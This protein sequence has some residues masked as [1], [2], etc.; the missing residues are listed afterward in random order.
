LIIETLERALAELLEAGRVAT[1]KKWLELAAVAA[2]HHSGL[3]LAE[4]EVALRD[5]DP[6][7]AQVLGERS[8]FLSRGGDAAAR[9]H[10]VAARAAH[11]RDD[12]EGVTRNVK[13]AE[14][15]ATTMATKANALWIH[16]S[17]ALERGDE[18]VS[19]ILDRLRA[20]PD[21]SAEFA[22]RLRNAEG[23]MLFEAHADVRAS[24]RAY[25]L[26][27]ALLPHV[28]DPFSRTALLNQRAYVLT[29]LGSY[30]D[31][32]RV[33]QQEI[34]EA[35]ASGLQFAVDHGLLIRTN[36]L[37]GLRKLQAARQ[38]FEELRARPRQENITANARIQLAKLRVALG[39]LDG[40]AV[41][42]Q[43][44]PHPAL[45]VS[46]HEE[47]L[48]YNAVIQAARGNA[49][50]ARHAITKGERASVYGVAT[51]IRRLALAILAINEEEEAASAQA[52][53]TLNTVIAKGHVDA[54]V[55]ACR[56]FP[57]L[58]EVAARADP[59]LGHRLS[60]IFASSR[61]IDLGRRAGIEM[62]RELRHSDGLSPRER[63]VYEH[64][65]QGRSNREI[66]TA[67]FIS[68]S[69]TKVH[70]RHIFEKLGVHSRAEAAM[71]ASR[72]DN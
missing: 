10:L 5:G 50:G 16:F 34:A 46:L 12:P 13:R 42:L 57:R 3:V 21:E 22:L 17:S 59:D 36:A 2:C 71:L 54:T 30:Q 58:A 33:I 1:V 14:A 64:L 43:H 8:A 37:I 11:L 55:T 31:A 7:K 32:L 38:T 26:A 9:A 51:M 35:R 72:A 56:A 24:A 63:E 39:D 67:L 20:F 69:T 40:A 27:A 44:E 4:A 19:E 23:F 66:A 45:S 60:T 15:T 62:P 29:A 47:L 25:E 18:I 70:V 48:A 65:I 61:D 53:E 52:V 41:H 49:A 28:N 68:E 6:V